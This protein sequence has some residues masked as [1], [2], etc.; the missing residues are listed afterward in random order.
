MKVSGRALGTK[1]SS[2]ILHPY[3]FKGILRPLARR[4]P[5]RRSPLPARPSVLILRRRRRLRRPS[6]SFIARH[7][8]VERLPRPRVIAGFVHRGGV[9]DAAVDDRV[10][11]RLRVADV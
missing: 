3:L 10:V 11:H 9:E 7:L 4:P 8:E 1:P 5:A 6:P 2:F